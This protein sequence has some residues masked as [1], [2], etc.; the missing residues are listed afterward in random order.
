M[1]WEK[2]WREQHAHL[3]LM[4][5]LM[6]TMRIP[7]RFLSGV[8]RARRQR[9]VVAVTMEVLEAHHFHV[10]LEE[11]HR[12]LNLVP[13]QQ[14]TQERIQRRRVVCATLCVGDVLTVFSCSFFGGG[15]GVAGPPFGG[16]FLFVF[17]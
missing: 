1:S 17:V 6:S 13:H 2:C 14:E 11:D 4:A 16:R 10:H 3:P 15:G 12:H 8:P 9:V 7:T 5:S